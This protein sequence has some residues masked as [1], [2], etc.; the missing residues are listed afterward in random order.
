MDAKNLV[1][2]QDRDIAN[3]L[4][5]DSYRVP[6]FARANGSAVESSNVR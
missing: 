6:G 1:Q 2:R 3:E 4:L 5:A